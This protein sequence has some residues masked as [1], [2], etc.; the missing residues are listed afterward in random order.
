MA[1]R[2]EYLDQECGLARSL[3]IVGERWTLLIVRDAFYGV[4]RFCDFRDH[5]AIP[6]AVLTERL[7]F[8]V[9]QG[10]LERVAARSGRDEYA[11]TGRGRAL[12]PAVWALM[13]W[14]SEF[15]LSDAQRRPFT[16]DG[17]GG[18]IGA[19]GAC[20][21]CRAVPR[22]DELTI[23][24]RRG[25]PRTAKTDPVSVALTTS[26]PLLTPIRG[27]AAPAARPEGSRPTR[28]GGARAGSVR[29][30]RQR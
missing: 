28:S 30:G 18:V 17:C 26:H 4:R 13:S 23:N 8:L 16:H 7:N 27:R 22:P 24:P 9:E 29:G 14:G 10:V 1:L 25:W 19:D 5:L 15:Y 6:R 21:A 11:L 12:W 3:E 2:R 20:D